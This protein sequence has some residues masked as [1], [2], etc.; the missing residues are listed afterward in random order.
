MPAFRMKITGVFDPGL[1]AESMGRSVDNPVASPPPR[2]QGVIEEGTVSIGDAILFRRTGSRRT[3][4]AIAQLG[5]FVDSA[6]AGSYAGEPVS[7]TFSQLRSNEAQPGDEL[8]E[9]K[10]SSAETWLTVSPEAFP[11]RALLGPASCNSWI[12]RIPDVLKGLNSRLNQIG[13]PEE[14][15][16]ELY[17][18]SLIGVCPRCNQYCAGKALL[19][20]EMFL[21]ANALF[22]GDSG[23][24]ERMLRG[25][26]LNYSCSSTDFDLFWCPD[27]DS[28]MLSNLRQRG[29]N[30]DPGM[31]GERD[32]IW[33][34][35]SEG[36]EPAPGR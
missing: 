19:R 36:N 30:I 15:L 32:R 4:T 23:G 6:K 17:N 14:K 27:L 20:M 28:D 34:P 9:A 7:L 25:F 18:T 5:C 13:V 2:I 1:I 8:F 31:Q 21:G 24:F 22:T 35:Q 26:C 3:V 12:R 33:K 11:K 10:H 29:V 16:P